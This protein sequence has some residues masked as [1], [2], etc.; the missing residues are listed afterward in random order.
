MF[1]I[2]WFKVWFLLWSNKP[3][4]WESMSVWLRFWKHLKTNLRV[5]S[6][7]TPLAQSSSEFLWKAEY[8]PTIHWINK[9]TDFTHPLTHLL[10][11][12]FFHFDFFCFKYDAGISI[13]WETLSGF[14]TLKMKFWRTLFHSANL[15]L[16]CRSWQ[17]IDSFSWVTQSWNKNCRKSQTNTCFV[18]HQKWRSWKSDRSSSSKIW[19][20]FCSS[21]IHRTT[22]TTTTVNHFWWFTIS[23]LF[24]FVCSSLFLLIPSFLFLLFNTSSI[25]LATLNVCLFF[26]IC[27]ILICQR[28]KQHSK[29]QSCNC[30][31][32]GTKRTATTDETKLMFPAHLDQKRPDNLMQNVIK[33]SYS[34]NVRGCRV[35]L[36]NKSW[37]SLP[38]ACCHG[39][40][41]RFKLSLKQAKFGKVLLLMIVLWELWL[42]GVKTEVQLMWLL[43]WLLMNIRRSLIKHL[44]KLWKRCC[45]CCN[46]F[47]FVFLFVLCVGDFVFHVFCSLI[48]LIDWLFFCCCLFVVELIS[49]RLS[50]LSKNKSVQTQLR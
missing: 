4:C 40:S 29:T 20:L 9:T 33:P 42:S 6:H 43:L 1:V 22:T 37:K 16:Q 13:F 17:V 32:W 48:D 7:L 21:T 2:K 11:F 50:R 30:G 47:C 26:W 45:E 35:S 34:S 14:A 27:V 8:P 3:K 31:K 12:F 36:K 19:C 23:V 15:G 46:L 49:H 18:K 24:C 38:L 44:L 41:S 25:L 39:F 5:D 28:N 10:L